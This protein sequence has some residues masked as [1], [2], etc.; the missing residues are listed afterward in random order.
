MLRCLEEMRCSSDFRAA[1]YSSDVNAGS[2]SKL[3][4]ISITST[5]DVPVLRVPYVRETKVTC[6]RIGGSTYSYAPVLGSDRDKVLRKGAALRQ[7]PN[8]AAKIERC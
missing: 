6:I 2:S 4:A 1:A 3:W 7:A 5:V 8:S